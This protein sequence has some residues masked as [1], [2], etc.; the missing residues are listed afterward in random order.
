MFHLFH[1]DPKH[2]N[3]LPFLWFKDNPSKRIIENKMTVH[4]FSKRPSPAIATFGLGKIA[5]DGEEKY[6]KKKTRLR[7]QKLLCKWQ[8]DVMP[9]EE[10]RRRLRKEH[11]RSRPTAIATLPWGPLEHQEGLFHP[12]CLAASKAL[13]M[14]RSSVCNKLSVRASGPCIPSHPGR[15][16][17]TKQLVI[18]RKKVN[19]NYLLGWDDPL[20]K[21]M[22][23]CC[24]WWRDVMPKLEKYWFLVATPLKDSALS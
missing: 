9:H 16:N 3:F 6:W 17:N 5:N 20:R 12:L 18:M 22:K 7:L 4:L 10:N 11:Q 8:A 19:G 21:N 24:S 15:E 23:H 2:Q 13:H 1:V 14:D